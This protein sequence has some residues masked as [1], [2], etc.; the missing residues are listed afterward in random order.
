MNHVETMYEFTLVLHGFYMVRVTMVQISKSRPPMYT[1][2]LRGSYMVDH[3]GTMYT[4][5]HLHGPVTF[6]TLFLRGILGIYMILTWSGLYES[7]EVEV[8]L[9]IQRTGAES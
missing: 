1:W 5:F 8:P 9:P 3:V 6:S 2:C 4:L 7:V